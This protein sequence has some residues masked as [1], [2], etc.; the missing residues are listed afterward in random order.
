MDKVIYETI[1]EGIRGYFI[2]D[3][4]IVILLFGVSVMVG[5]LKFFTD[6]TKKPKAG[7]IDTRSKAEA[8]YIQAEARASDT[9]LKSIKA[10]A[11]FS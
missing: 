10:T 3:D 7:V 6:G 5:T 4:L 8:I 2:E 11:I 1:L 9:E